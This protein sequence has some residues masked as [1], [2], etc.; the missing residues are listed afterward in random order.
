M[1]ANSRTEISKTKPREQARITIKYLPYPFQPIYQIKYP[2]S[3]FV[4]TP[5]QQQIDIVPC[6]CQ[7]FPFYGAFPE[8]RPVKPLRPSV[9][10]I[11]RESRLPESTSSREKTRISRIILR[12]IAPTKRKIEHRS[13]VLDTVNKTTNKQ[14]AFHIVSYSKNKTPIECIR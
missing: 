2:I 5:H 6:E 3:H 4:P 14:K 7:P 10:Q 13:M 9:T 11:F 12:C 8:S 1:T